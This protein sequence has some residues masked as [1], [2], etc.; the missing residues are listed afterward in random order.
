MP[1]VLK[2]APAVGVA[3]GLLAGQPPAGDEPLRPRFHFTPARNFMNDPNGLVFYK[4]EYHLFYQHNPFGATWGHMSW[5]HAVSPDM[6]RWQHLPVALSEEDGVMIFSGSV[7]VDGQNSSGFCEAKD[8]DRSCLVAVYTGHGHGKQTQNLAYSNDRGRTWTKYARNPVIDL[9]LKDFRDPKVFWAEPT[10][11]WIMVTVLPDQHKVRFFSSPDLK[12]WTALSDFGPAGATGGVWECPDLFRLPIEGEPGQMRW[13]LDVDINP[14]GIAGG[15]AGQ[16][17]VGRFDGT[18]FVPEDPA[19]PTLWA[20]YGK[21]FYASLSFSD[22]PVSDGRRIWMGW[23]SNWQYANEEPTAPWRGAQSV[24]R[25]LKLHRTADGLRLVQAPSRELEALRTTPHATTISSSGPLPPSAEIVLEVRPGDW[26]EAGIRLSNAAGEEVIVG[27][28]STPL[29]VFV[30]RR[31]S[32]KTPFHAAYPG[33]HAGPVAWRDGT[34]TLRILFDRSVVEVFANDG[35]TVVT[36]RVFPTQPLDR[37]ELLPPDGTPPAARM[38]TLG[39][40]AAT[41]VEMNLDYVDIP[42]TLEQGTSKA[43]AIVRARLGD[44]EVRTEARPAP[45]VRSVYKLEVLEALKR[46]PELPPPSEVLRHGGDLVSASGTTRYVEEGFPAFEPRQEYL[47]F[48][49]WNDYLK[50]YEMAFGP[51]AAFRI[52]SDGRLQALGREPV[53][54]QLNERD[55]REVEAQI[56]KLDKKQK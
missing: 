48:L 9:G 51:N 20:D 41:V 7:V 2:L 19:S 6:L 52:S 49:Y 3:L 36:D 43:H 14:G 29:E 50:A 53:A 54:Q 32:R 42:D 11:R 12:A 45:V 27:I 35:E 39:S 37:L 16:Y 25:T 38:W 26:K 23:I 56:R 10:Q 18:R 31:H 22:V 55:V 5:G 17:F 15:S 44:A 24:P 21:D 40:Q 1:N 8:G 33:R 4:G 47:L 34:I 28:A 30:D 46:S 13:V